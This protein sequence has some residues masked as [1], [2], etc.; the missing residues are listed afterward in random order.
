MR[1]MPAQGLISLGEVFELEPSIQPGG[2]D[3]DGGS[4]SDTPPGSQQG[5]AGPPT[6]RTTSMHSHSGAL[7]VIHSFGE[8]GL[9]EPGSPADDHQLVYQHG[10]ASDVYTLILQGR[11]LVR[12]GALSVDGSVLPSLFRTRGW[13][14]LST[15]ASLGHCNWLLV[16]QIHVIECCAVNGRLTV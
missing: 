3:S 15:A 2:D 1:C 9:W 11:V 5:A 13:A 6:L 10:K 7:P 14:K 8:Q 16:V 4:I 12:T